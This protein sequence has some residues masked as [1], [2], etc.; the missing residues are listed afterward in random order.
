M[1]FIYWGDFMRKLYIFISIFV[2]VAF[3]TPCSISS[4]EITEMQGQNENNNI[5]VKAN[6]TW[7]SDK[8]FYEVKAEIH[9]KTNKMIQVLYDCNDLI[10]YSG[11]SYENGC[12]DAYS[13]GLEE[14]QAYL[15]NTEIPKKLFNIDNGTFNITI[16]LQL[17]VD[18]EKIND[19]TIP[20]KA[21][22][23]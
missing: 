7:N 3:L 1:C 16:R 9:N 14:G 21:A 8:E 18:S 11:K 22:N 20:L 19:I 23:K 4:P 2:V 15:D 17:D 6:A 13:M 5:S 10:S 12:N